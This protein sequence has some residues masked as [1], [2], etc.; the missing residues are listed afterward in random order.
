M[1]RFQ[2]LRYTEISDFDRSIRCQED[3]GSFDVSVENFVGVNRLDSQGQLHEPVDD[4][5]LGYQ[6]PPLLPV[7]DKEGQVSL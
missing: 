2:H 6:L 4:N 3:V 7:F 1:G 5:V